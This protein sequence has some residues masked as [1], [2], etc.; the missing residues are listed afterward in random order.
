MD[1]IYKN[2]SSEFEKNQHNKTEDIH[3]PSSETDPFSSNAIGNYP[4]IQSAENKKQKEPVPQVVKPAKYNT[5]L[6][7]FENE[8]AVKDCGPKNRDNML[9][10]GELAFRVDKITSVKKKEKI[11]ESEKHSFKIPEEQEKQ[12]EDASENIP[13][14]TEQ[15][16]EKDILYE[17]ESAIIIPAEAQEITTTAIMIEEEEIEVPEKLTDELPANFDDVSQIDLNEAEIIA[18]ED[19]RSFDDEDFLEELDILPEDDHTINETIEPGNSITLEETSGSI[20]K[21]ESLI[22]NNEKDT[23]KEENTRENEIS[24]FGDEIRVEN[25][26]FEYIEDTIEYAENEEH[27]P[28]LPAGNI[29]SPESGDYDHHNLENTVQDSVVFSEETEEPE[30]NYL[31]NETENDENEQLQVQDSFSNQTDATMSQDSNV[32][33]INNINKYTADRNILLSGKGEITDDKD[34]L[35]EIT[36]NIVDYTG[37]KSVELTK[38]DTI[39]KKR[40]TGLI[41]DNYPAFTDLLKEQDEKQKFFDDDIAFIDNSF[42]TK[43]HLKKLKE[44]ESKAEEI[45]EQK[46]TALR[47]HALGLVPEEIELIEDQL[48]KINRRKLDIGLSKIIA[49]H[50]QDIKDT[51]IFD[52]YKY[53]IPKKNSLLDNE[54]KSIENDISSSTAL[55]LEEDI[56]KIKT[57]LEDSMKREIEET[58]QDITDRIIIFED[59][60]GITGMDFSKEKEIKDIKKLL[61]YLNELLSKLPEDAIKNFAESEYYDLYKKVLDDMD[62]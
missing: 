29:N 15:S 50:D 55:I 44:A 41:R 12:E 37:G 48:F 18:E 1:K 42:I 3:E 16:Y 20:D 25:T 34:E 9:S 13:E 11:R 5:I 62:K 58:I 31:Y 57:K 46:T 43:E 28:E 14:I 45:T 24:D 22:E 4:E 49:G 17:Q 56:E 61:K 59:N 32:L 54:K 19:L 53:I 40:I 2:N 6:D 23:E 7:E 47:E 33:I 10:I 52:K 36:S 26:P 38:S 35:E 27:E 39:D 21:E 8:V 51:I 30:D 60:K